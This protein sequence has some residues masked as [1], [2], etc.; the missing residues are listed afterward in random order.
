MND[1]VPLPKS[2]PRP[3]E[4]S[5][6]EPGTDP[7]IEVSR[8][9]VKKHAHHEAA[10]AAWKAGWAAGIAGVGVAVGLMFGG[11]FKIEAMA[12]EKSNQA[13]KDAGAETDRKLAP[14]ER[15]VAV[16]KTKVD[17]L[18]DDVADLKKSAQDNA[19]TQREML[20]LLK[21]RE[22]R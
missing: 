19:E 2:G 6:D 1:G 9:Y 20:R 8:D 13:V 18:S 21:R 12:Q 10:K 15:D 22:G 4:P 17:T 16:I 7:G 14:I 3:P 5:L 11:W